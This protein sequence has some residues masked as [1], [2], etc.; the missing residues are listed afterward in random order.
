MS[1][2]LEHVLI[3]MA[4]FVLVLGWFACLALEYFAGRGV[5]HLLRRWR[6]Q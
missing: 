1:S 3:A 2:F 6:R 4:T 5:R